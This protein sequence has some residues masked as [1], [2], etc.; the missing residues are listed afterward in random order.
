[1]DECNR[2]F[3]DGR[4]ELR[5]AFNRRNAEDLELIAIF[6]NYV[7]LLAV[8]FVTDNGLQDDTKVTPWGVR[9]CQLPN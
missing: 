7:M 9:L 3:G 6:G 5:F 4:A 1:M 2:R 8:V